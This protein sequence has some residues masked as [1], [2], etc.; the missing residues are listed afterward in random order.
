MTQRHRILDGRYVYNGM[1]FDTYS[2]PTESKQSAQGTM[3][4][5]RHFINGH[6]DLFI[7][8]W[9]TTPGNT[10]TE[11]EEPEAGPEQ[12]A[13]EE[14]ASDH[15]QGSSGWGTGKCVVRTGWW[16]PPPSTVEVPQSNQNASEQAQLEG[17]AG[18]TTG[19]GS[20]P[21]HQGWGEATPVTKRDSQETDKAGSPDIQEEEGQDGGAK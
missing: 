17:D 13:K 5:Y 16:G 2:E 6:G 14:E 10:D 3:D 4:S 21:A 15:K 7:H 12:G 18:W 20:A 11:E 1:Y 9:F 19:W 8:E